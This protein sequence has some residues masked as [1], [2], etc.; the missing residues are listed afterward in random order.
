MWFS[1]GPRAVGLGGLLA[2]SKRPPWPRWLPRLSCVPPIKGRLLGETWLREQ[3]LSQ[4]K[5]IM[6]L[7]CIF[8]REDC[9]WIAVVYRENA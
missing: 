3:R 2:P 1:L 9:E 5:R 4:E 8:V 7:L 6:S